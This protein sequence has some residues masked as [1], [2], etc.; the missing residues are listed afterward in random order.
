LAGNPA[1]DHYQAMVEKLDTLL[2]KMK[3]PVRIVCA[4]TGT[5]SQMA[6]RYA[7]E[8][9]Y[10][11]AFFELNHDLFKNAAQRISSESMVWYSDAL[12]V[13][14]DENDDDV[15]SLIDIAERENLPVREAVI[16]DLSQK[17]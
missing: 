16:S 3:I 2:S 15:Q 4:S 6:E 9:D 14:W 8:N 10:F 11:I 12:F 5:M 13:L 7:T 1:P 17:T